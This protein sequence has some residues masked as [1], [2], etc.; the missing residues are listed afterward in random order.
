VDADIAWAIAGSA[1]SYSTL[2]TTDG[3]ATWTSQAGAT[4][5][6]AISALDANTAWVVTTSTVRKTTD[7]GATWSTQATE[8]YFNDISAL[9]TTTVWA[10]GISGR[11]GKT[12]DGTNWFSQDSGIT[13]TLYSISAVD[14]ETA[15]AVGQG[16]IILKTEDGGGEPQAPVISSVV[17]GAAMAGQLIKIEGSHFGYEQGSSF[18][19]FGTVQPTH[20]TSWKDTEIYCTVP[21]TAAGATEVTV[22]TGVAASGAYPFEVLGASENGWNIQDSGT[23]VRLN[24]V[25]A[26]DADTAWAVGG[27]GAIL[28]TS[29]GGETWAAQD[30]GTSDYLMG[31]S[32]VDADTAFAVGTSGDY[33]NPVFL[34]TTDGGENWISLPPDTS[35]AN[36]LSRVSAVDADNVWVTGAVSGYTPVI[37]KTSDGGASWEKKETGIEMYM[38][39]HKSVCAADADT[40]WVTGGS[41]N[42]DLTTGY[43]VKTG[44]GGA[45]WSAQ[46]LGYIDWSDVSAVDTQTVWITGR[47]YHYLANP[48]T[49]NPCYLSTDGGATWKDLPMPTTRVMS[50]I[51]AVDA[52]EA[53]ITEASNGRIWKT[54]TGGNSWSQ[55][56]DLLEYIYD[57]SAADSDNAWA[58]GANGLILHTSGGGLG[59]APTVTSVEPNQGSQLNIWFGITDLAGTGFENGAEVRL[60]KG[61]IVLDAYNVNVVSDTQI[62]CTVGLF[63]A[64]PG[65]YDVV[66]V[67]PDGQEARLEG[68]FTVM[69]QC[70]QGA[71]A[72]LMVF[73]LMMG[74]LS[75]AGTGIFRKRR[76]KKS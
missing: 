50:L 46:Q 25:S 18:V 65:A 59:P 70:G 53:W 6:D 15:W 10:A 2:V 1:P 57:I 66:V 72:S 63:G 38:M 8:T 31:V 32:A 23:T 20:Y 45:A 14:A 34:K 49:D 21:A 43:V 51:E 44:D 28:K 68:G 16:G 58:V 37:L 17:P 24:S 22:T 30:S 42:M 33:L 3:G 52:E 67:N 26:V 12:T 48:T 69:S 64:E 61:S 5:T 41:I 71:G 73:G 9:D 35:L 4:T 39:P 62:T 40:A 19:S 74:L 54:I 60:E 76:G 7:G 36:N 47:Y 27:E 56:T 11:I 29:D 55:Q 75:L 13:T